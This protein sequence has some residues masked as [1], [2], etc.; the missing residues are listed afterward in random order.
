MFIPN[1]FQVANC[2][3]VYLTNFTIS[4]FL[5]IQNS[6]P[7]TQV[8]STGALGQKGQTYQTYQPSCIIQ[9]CPIVIYE[10]YLVFNFDKYIINKGLFLNY[11]QLQITIINVNLRN[12][13]RTCVRRDK[14]NL[15]V[16]INVIVQLQYTSRF[17]LKDQ[18]PPY[19]QYEYQQSGFLL[20]ISLLSCYLHRTD[21]QQ[22]HTL[23]TPQFDLSG[24]VHTTFSARRNVCK[25]CTL[26][27]M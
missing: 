27:L 24:K 25:T 26:Q 21:K 12:Y 13:G 1:S 14:C 20:T 18:L 5:V 10:Y 16:D 23:I 4:N 15:Q 9:M 22:C 17:M 6:E 7:R 3:L 11:L 2:N 19:C 8:F